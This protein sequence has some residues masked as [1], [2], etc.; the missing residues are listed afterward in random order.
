MKEGRDWL[1][2]IYC[3]NHHLEL[4]ALKENDSFKKVDEIAFFMWKY[5]MRDSGKAKW[6]SMTIAEQLNVLFV[7]FNKSH[8]THFQN[9]KYHAIK[10]LIINYIQSVNYCEHAIAGGAKVCKSDIAVKLKGFLKTL[11]YDSE[12]KRCKLLP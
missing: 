1:K 11:S 10:A 3:G 4:N 7:A 5:F 6:L 8:G 2:I 9:H 12:K